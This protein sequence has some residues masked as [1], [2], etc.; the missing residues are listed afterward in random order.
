MT[1]CNILTGWSTLNTISTPRRAN[2]INGL[3]KCLCHDNDNYLYQCDC[4]PSHNGMLWSWNQV[5][6]NSRD[7]HICDFIGKCVASPGNT[8]F[9][10]QLIRHHHLDEEGQ[11]FNFVD[12]LTHPGFY[13][14][15]N[16]HG[17]CLSVKGN[18]NRIGA[19]VLASDCNPLEAGQ[20]WKW[21]N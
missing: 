7:R 16:D 6:L 3:G 20:R 10:Y 21:I 1:W 12:S 4:D 9:E 15:K 18:T 13:I 8:Y 17:K 2:L 5:S 11:R 14:I 19:E